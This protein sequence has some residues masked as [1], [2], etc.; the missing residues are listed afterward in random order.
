MPRRCSL[1]CMRQRVNHKKNIEV[2]LL[3]PLITGRPVGTVSIEAA[4]RTKWREYVFPNNLA[5]RPQQIPVTSGMF[6]G[7]IVY[8]SL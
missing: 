3:L 7:A 5:D 6:V 1:L 2:Q 8:C 4:K